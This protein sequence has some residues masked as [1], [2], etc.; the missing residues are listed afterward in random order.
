MIVTRPASALRAQ[1]GTRLADLVMVDDNPGDVTLMRSAISEVALPVRVHVAE[2]AAGFFALMGLFP[3]P[4]ALVLLDINLPLLKGPFILG[5]IREDRAWRDVP[6][7][8][9]TSA[10]GGADLAECR[11]FATEVITK[12]ALYDGYLEVAQGFA[13]YLGPGPETRPETRKERP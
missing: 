2:D 10:Q 4:P 7:I 1:E 6:V 8:I 5:E 9:L 3:D 12:P 11:A 13:R